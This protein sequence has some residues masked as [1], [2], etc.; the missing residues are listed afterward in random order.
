MSQI[1]RVLIVVFALCG[2]GAVTPASAQQRES[3]SASDFRWERPIVTNGAGPRRLAVDVPLLTGAGQRLVD[4]RL[5][6]ATGREVPYLLIPRPTVQPSWTNAALLPI[7][8]VDTPS[9]KTSGFEA[10]LGAMQIVD[11]FRINYHVSQ[12]FLKRVRLEGS[13]DRSRWTALVL[14][15]TVFNLPDEQ[16]R[17][18]EL[19]FTPG[20]YRYLRVTWDDTNSGRL[21]APMSVEA[22]LVS[23][24]LPSPPLTTPLAIERRT[25]GAQR[26]HYRIRLPGGHLPIVGLSFDLGGGHVMRNASVYDSRL[27]GT[28]V[29]PALL[30]NAKLRRVV[31]GPLSA[32]S[33]DIPLNPP[34]EPR[35]DLVVDDG[36]NPPLEIRSISAV[37]AEQP[38][39]YFESDGT[40]LTAR[41][42]SPAL[43]S[44]R[45]DLE[46][47]RDS[48]RN[49]IMAVAD[50]AWGE[51]RTRTAEEQA[52][53]PPP[54][55]P[56]AGA[57]LDPALFGYLRNLPPG[58]AGLM[59][60]PLD[61][62]VLAHS[63]GTP[64]A[65]R[66]V[67][68]IDASNRQVPY[69]VEHA[70]EPLTLDLSFTRLLQP[71][72]ALGSALSKPTVYKVV[73]P[74]ENLPSQH[75]LLTTSA[76]V[77]TRVIA[78][79]IER[80]PNR[81]HRDPWIEMIQRFSWTHADQDTPTP[82]ASVPLPPAD[83]TELL[84]VVEEGDNMPLPIS[85]AQVLLPAYRLRFYRE[86]G[87]SLRLAY[88]RR[89]LDAP[90]YDLALL[91]PQ[92]LGFAATEIEAAREDAAAHAPATAAAI[93]SP[94]LFWSSL[95]IAV[96]VLLGLIARLLRKQTAA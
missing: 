25:S 60:L 48:L 82:A 68:L 79:G 7:A 62:A 61:A 47:M 63:A 14:E 18:T 57:S 74:F 54:A 89:D 67:R 59:A 85:S 23:N 41:Y 56:T 55:L 78:V 4:L 80:R 81:Y 90:R 36:D 21:P 70:S 96:V 64:A 34:V 71:P 73:F 72:P 11:R 8:P 26:S 66:D 49:G 92:V 32:S 29:I 50:A 77:F 94:R 35:L 45:Y 42:G 33:L 83:A 87:A 44:P 58:E 38:W 9:L 15:G 39:I 20:S 6:D 31:Q 22:R 86:R 76:R 95:V 40:A 46:V 28:E 24:I 37:F 3:S 10:D 91:A 51:A 88:G 17:Q 5:F 69:L 19:A 43:I 27:S 84:L 93:V 30:G 52:S 2:A 53:G 65:F 1:V 16:L 75:L 13:G 12:S